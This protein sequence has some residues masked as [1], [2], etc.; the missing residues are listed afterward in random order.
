MV[1]E[2]RIE[3]EVKKIWMRGRLREWRFHSLVTPR[4]EVEL[5]LPILDHRVSVYSVAGVV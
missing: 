1:V 4:Q 5:H 3:R 2:A